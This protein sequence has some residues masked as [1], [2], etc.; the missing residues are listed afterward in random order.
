MLG[1]GTF[2]QSYG[3]CNSEKYK[4]QEVNVVS[5]RECGEYY[6]ENMITERIICAKAKNET[7]WECLGDTGGKACEI[8]RSLTCMLEKKWFVLVFSL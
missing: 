1:W 2:K 8:Y 6:G 5:R 3:S 7:L 4:A